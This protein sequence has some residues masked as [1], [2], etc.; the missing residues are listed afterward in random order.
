MQLFVHPDDGAAPIL[1][2]IQSARRTIHLHIFRLDQRKIEAA[3][4]AAVVRGVDVCTLIAH[5][6]A[7]GEPALRKLE[8]RLLAIGVTVARSADEFPR[9][10][11]KMMVVDHRTLYVLGYNLTRNDMEKTRS[12]GVSTRKRALVEEALRLFDADFNRKPY[13]TS[14]SGFLVSP[15][16]SRDRL[17]ALIGR[18]RKQLL[19][20]GVV[21]DPAMLRLLKD[22]QTAGVDVRVIGKMEKGHP[23]ILSEKYPGRRLHLNAVVRDARIAFLGSQS[24]RKGELDKRREVGIVFKDP[25]TVKRI[26]EIFEAD[27]AKTDAGSKQ[28]KRDAKLAK[29]ARRKSRKARTAA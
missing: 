21:S 26:V 6:N 24:L 22:R 4:A 1:R 11:G 20:Y 5:I 19:I 10:H 16:N 28:A 2:A 8:Q 27:W 13:T 17:A 29:D 7:G 9:Y 25:A 18:A 3:L 23:A 12:L 15:V 14:T